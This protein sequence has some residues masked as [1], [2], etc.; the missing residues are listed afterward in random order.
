MAAKPSQSQRQEIDE[1]AKYFRRLERREGLTEEDER[2]RY[3]A[4]WGGINGWRP[5]GYTYTRRPLPP[6]NPD[7]SD[8]SEDTEPEQ[9]V[10]TSNQVNRKRPRQTGDNE[11]SLNAAYEPDGTK[12]I[13]PAKRRRMRRVHFAK[14]LIRPRRTISPP[15]TNSEGSSSSS[16]SSDILENRENKERTPKQRKEAADTPERLKQCQMPISPPHSP[17]V[18][19]LSGFQY[20]TDKITPASLRDCI[21]SSC[22]TFLGEETDNII[23]AEYQAAGFQDSEME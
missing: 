2:E 11:E 14:P 9:A 19:W 4:S 8:D 1:S 6:S 23:L 18:S 12:Y 16:D 22:Y 13:R 21:M 17:K 10:V 7:D 20:P 5:K 3:F 15:L